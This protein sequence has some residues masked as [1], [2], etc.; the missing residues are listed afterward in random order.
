MPYFEEGEVIR[1]DRYS[2]FTNNFI[3][4]SNISFNAQFSAFKKK[5]ST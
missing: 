1:F 2:I 4:H 5:N 3:A